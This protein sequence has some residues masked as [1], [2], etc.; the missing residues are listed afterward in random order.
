MRTLLVLRSA[1]ICGWS[2]YYSIF[3]W[4]TWLTGWYLRVLAQVSFFALI[5]KLLGSDAKTQYLLVGNSVLLATVVSLFAIPSTAWERWAG[6]LP[7]LVAAPTS[8]VVV[9]AGRSVAILVD[10]VAS[11]LGAFF[12]AAAIFGVPLPWP[13]VLLVVPLVCLVALASYALALFLGGWIVRAPAFRNVASNV[14]HTTIMAIAG[15]NVPVAFYPR[16]VE[17]LAEVLPLTHGLRAIRGVLA[18][19]AAGAVL[20]NAALELAVGLGWLVLALL[21]FERFAEHGRR[22]GSIEFG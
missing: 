3:S 8:P 6:T 4:R 17:W 16:P 7:L 18:G 13:R 10:A 19:S 12:A 9:F 15:V 22:D 14:T 1:A 5:G 20:G 11:S 2:E 21:T